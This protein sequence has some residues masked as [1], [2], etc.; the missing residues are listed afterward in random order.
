MER[1]TQRTNGVVVYVGTH[2]EEAGGQTAFEVSSRGIREI[3][4]RL[5]A[6]ED[7]GLTPEEINDLASVREISPETEYAINKHADS[8]IDRLDKLLAQTDDDDRL[9]ELA[10]ADKEGRVVVLPCKVGDTVWAILDGAKYVRKCVVEFVN[11]GSCVTT[12]VFTTADRVR[13]QCGA[14]ADAFGKTVF[15]TREDA[16]EVLRRGEA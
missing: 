7:A 3:L 9:R 12:I 16:E 11:I 8:I 14:R 1:L 6:Y 10:R 2:N 5:A 4:A 15:R 13:E